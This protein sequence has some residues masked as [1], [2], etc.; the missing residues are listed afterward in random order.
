MGELLAVSE[1]LHTASQEL[2]RH[3]DSPMLAGKTVVVR[4]FND[5]RSNLGFLQGTRSIS[6]SLFATAAP[7]L[8]SIVQQSH[9]IHHHSVDVRLEP[10]WIP[11][12]HRTVKPHALAD[13]LARAARNRG[14]RSPQYLRDTGSAR[15]KGP[16]SC[17]SR[18][19]CTGRRGRRCGTRPTFESASFAGRARPRP[20]RKSDPRALS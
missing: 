18:Q 6:A 8:R 7:V 19:S 16:C 5:N 4:I 2:A 20:F 9:A 3:A 17:R 10:H 13:Q 11:G 15:R 1:C 12:H 14:G